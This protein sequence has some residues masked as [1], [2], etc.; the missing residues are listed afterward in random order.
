MN[1][2]KPI[3]MLHYS[4]FGTERSPNMQFDI[5]RQN[6]LLREK[7]H[8]VTLNQAEPPKK[9]GH[10]KTILELRREIK[11]F[12]PYAVH[13]IGVKEGFHCVVAACLAGCKKRILVTHGFSG[14]SSVN[15]W[16]RRFVFQYFIEP[17]TLILSTQVQCNSMFSMSQSII[18]R[19]AKRKSY[20]IYNFLNIPDSLL[21][22]KKTWRKEHN[23]D[24]K[25]FIVI[26]IGNMH[27]GKGYDI[28]TQV[29]R[30]TYTSN[31]SNVRFVVI[32]DGSYRQQFEYDNSDF[33]KSKKLICTGRLPYEDTISI[34]SECNLFYLPT[35]FETLG[36]V[37]AEAGFCSIPSIGSNVGAVGEIIHNG[38]T[39]YLL[40]QDDDETAAKI[41]LEL[42][43]ETEKCKKMGNEAR[44][45]IE[46]MFSSLEI[47]KQLMEKYDS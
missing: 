40:T 1:I 33:V 8:F 39:G 45:H 26:T 12:S 2:D 4:G 44:K 29:I 24:D 27:L 7:Y 19:F 42:S 14:V 47:A 20:L 18:K 30:K 10:I 34:L 23:I 43:S 9:H 15:N 41:I 28:L 5:L 36:M 35:R 16:A 17:I 13:I 25:E 3:V 22:K 31:N 46:K 38:E 6:P 37:F 21:N 11:R 32:G